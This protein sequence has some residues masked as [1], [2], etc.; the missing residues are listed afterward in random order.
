MH[1]DIIVTDVFVH[2]VTDGNVKKIIGTFHTGKIEHLREAMLLT[3][4][5]L[6]DVANWELRCEPS[7]T[8]F[9]PK[10]AA[11]RLLCCC[12][13][14]RG[15]A[16]SLDSNGAVNQ[17]AHQFGDRIL[18][19]IPCANCCADRSEFSARVMHAD[20]YSK[21]SG[22]FAEV[23]HMWNCAGKEPFVLSTVV[24]NERGSRFAHTAAGNLRQLLQSRNFKTEAPTS[25][26]LSKQ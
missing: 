6:G 1:A 20:S 12:W 7:G 18:S 21:F 2:A 19:G 10:F 13:R 4:L 22:K 26:V 8:R 16:Q 14:A 25:C 5:V 3:N 23:P 15:Q 9:A 17:G 24:K 11:T